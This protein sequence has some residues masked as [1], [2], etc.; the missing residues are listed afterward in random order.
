MGYA[1]SSAYCSA[2]FAV[3]GLMQVLH[4]EL[5]SFGIEAAAVCPGAFRTDFRDS[6]S[7][8][9]PKAKVAAYDGT[10][11][12]QV[13]KFLQDNTHNQAGDPH[14]AAKFLFDF[15]ETGKKLPGRIL[16]GKDCCKQVKDD[17]KEQ[18][19]SI[20]SYEEASAKTNFAE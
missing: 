13:Q 19:A 14:L 5:A 4:Q 7:M 15:L 3:V 20:E 6:S 8:V 17:L 12:H 2:K 16:I 10:A 1:G 9:Y 11:S 18:I